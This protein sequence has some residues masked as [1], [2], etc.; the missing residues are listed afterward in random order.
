MEFEFSSQI[1]MVMHQ[2]T[3]RCHLKPDHKSKME[4]AQEETLNRDL[5]KSP[6]ELKIGLIGYYL[7]QGDIEKA[8]EVAEK[9]DDYRVIEK[10]RYVGKDGRQRLVREDE[11]D[12]FKNIKDLKDTT[13]KNDIF[14]I[15]KMNEAGANFNA[16]Q[17]VFGKEMLAH[18]VT[19]QWHF[20]AY[21]KRQLSSIL[22]EDQNTFMEMTGKLQNQCEIRV[23]L[24][25]YS[26]S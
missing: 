20:K 6:R 24:S 3:H 13:D 17:A 22:Q 11:V 7:A 12:S 8:N 23:H 5:R 4:Y 10:L 14:H 18:T 21:T 9:M 25:C 16:I 2:G 19:C 26:I 1:V 15:A